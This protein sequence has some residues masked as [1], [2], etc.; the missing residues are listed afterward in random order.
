M[1]QNLPTGCFKWIDVNHYKNIPNKKGM[2][3]EVDLEFPDHLHNLYN[4][5][6]LASEKIEIKKRMLSGY[7]K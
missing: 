4:D 6:P 3:L 7:S 2:I 1:S 5:Y